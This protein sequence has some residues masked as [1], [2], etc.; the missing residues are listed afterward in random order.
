MPGAADREGPSFKP[1]S[2][3]C[4]KS[5]DTPSPPPSSSSPWCTLAQRA[6]QA[7]AAP[8]HVA[9]PAR[10]EYALLRFNLLEGGKWDW[11]TP[12]ENTTEEKYA[13]FRSL[14]GTGRSQG[15]S[16]ID[17]ANQAGQ[18]G[19]EVIACR[20]RESRGTELWLKGAVR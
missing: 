4:V 8:A 3:A 1:R 15:L 12:T 9:P 13:I 18:Q 5:L 19:W 7:G 17:I 14:G 16:Y 6:P 20:E 10:W 2:A 11:I